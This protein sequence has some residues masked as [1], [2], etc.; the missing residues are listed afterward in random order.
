M[1]TFILFCIVITSLSYTAFAQTYHPVIK[2]Y[3]PVY[4]VP[5]AI[6]KPDP[7]LDYKIVAEMGE[8]NEK[9]AELYPAL[10]HAARMYNLHVHE[11]VPQNKLH[12]A[13][14]IWGE[15]IFIVLNNE[16]YKKKYG[17]DNPN[18][19]IIEEMKKAGIKIIACGQ[20]I[21]K[22][23][24]APNEIN[25]DVTIATSRFTAVSTLQMKGYAFFK[26]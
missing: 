9:P 11:G 5:F 18:L 7:S 19:K 6:E 20:S 8:K 21:M 4:D 15:A 17:V 2:S 23:N 12:I 13:D 1:K 3:G 22:F 10:S 14:V 25:P 26:Y 16:A 24:I